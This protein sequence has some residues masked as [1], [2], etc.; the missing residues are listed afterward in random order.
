MNEKKYEEALPYFESRDAVNPEDTENLYFYSYAL[1]KCVKF[2]KSVELA[3]RVTLRDPGNVKYLIHLARVLIGVKN[4]IE[5]DKVLDRIL[6]K[7]P[8]NERAL[9]LKKFL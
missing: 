9:K 7:E 8:D 2:K 5:A 1:W 6:K 4:Y 3:A